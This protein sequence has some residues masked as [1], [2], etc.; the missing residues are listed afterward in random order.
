[1]SHKKNLYQPLSDKEPEIRLLALFPSKSRE[2]QLSGSLSIATLKDQPSYMALSY[3][4]GHVSSSENICISGL[5]VPITTNLSCAL[6]YIRS[7][8]N[9]SVLWIDALSINQ[10]DDR[11]KSKQ[12]PLMRQIYENATRVIGWLGERRQ[13]SDAVMDLLK[14]MA[15][16]IRR[17]LA[18]EHQVDNSPISS[19]SEDSDSDRE[20]GQY[21]HTQRV[22]IRDAEK[23]ISHFLDALKP[24]RM[25]ELCILEENG[26]N[27]IWESIT[28]LLQREYWS[29][30]WIYQE[31]V[32]AQDLVLHCGDKSLQW[33]D[34][35]LI[36]KSF[37]LDGKAVMFR[38]YFE[39]SLWVQ[40]PENEFMGLVMMQHQE[41]TDSSHEGPVY[42]QTDLEPNLSV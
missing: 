21:F 22:T 11:E 36:A 34:L 1:M 32:V 10:C 42:F 24:T 28:A 23:D 4:W 20:G 40:L 41:E 30:A 5:D 26:G 14:T 2:A 38:R 17:D 25:P 6:R 7:R 9:T 19:S 13:N 12:V 27:R 16:E 37:E 39:S 35:I 31:I 18:T 3:V 29:R 33:E 15:G 8:T